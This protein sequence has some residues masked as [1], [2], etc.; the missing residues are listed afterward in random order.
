VN[1]RGAVQLSRLLGQRLA[2]L[3]LRS[4]ADRATQPGAAFKAGAHI[5]Q[6]QQEQPISRLARPAFAHALLRRTH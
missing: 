6:D 5:R 3:R 4:K 2:E 1:A